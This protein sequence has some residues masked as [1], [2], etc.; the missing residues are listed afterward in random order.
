MTEVTNFKVCTKC[1]SEKA[2]TDFHRDK[3]KTDGLRAWCKDCVSAHQ[4][5]YTKAN[6]ERITQVHAAYV[7]AHREMVREQ[8]RR[9]Y[10]NNHEVNLERDRKR[11]DKRKD[12][13]NAERREE[14]A[15]DPESGRAELRKWRKLNPEKARAADKRQW[16]KIRERV[17]S[18]PVFA[19]EYYQKKRLSSNAKNWKARETALNGYGGKCFCCGEANFDFLTLD[20]KG[21]N[22]YLHVTAKGKRITGYSLYIWAIKN[23]FPDTLQAACFNCNCARSMRGINGVCPHESAK[24]STPV[25]EITPV[26]GL[27]DALLFI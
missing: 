3:S 5:V 13:Y 16:A 22:G 14:W 4:S 27:G 12:T 15:D 25:P 24:K 2:V 18:D 1:Q 8:N 11:W 7:E 17:L 26:A 9:S 21:N 19:E 6:R 20:H 23:N 10:F